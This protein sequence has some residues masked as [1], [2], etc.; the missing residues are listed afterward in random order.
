MKAT[1]IFSLI[2]L[3]LTASVSAKVTGGNWENFPKY[4]NDP[5][6]TE[7]PLRECKGPYAPLSG[8]CGSGPDPREAFAGMYPFLAVDLDI[9]KGDGKIR[10]ARGMMGN[11]SWAFDPCH[12]LLCLLCPSGMEG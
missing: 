9:I 1:T 5:M 8:M 6:I 11:T 2:A 7:G 12:K 3:T 10:G 4:P